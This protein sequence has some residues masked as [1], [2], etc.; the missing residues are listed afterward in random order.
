MQK[1]INA[2]LS[3]NEK[4]KEQIR[5]RFLTRK[6]QLVNIIN[7]LGSKLNNLNKEVSKEIEVRDVLLHQE[8]ARTRKLRSE[9]LKA[10]D[11]LMSNDLAFKARD[12]FKTLVD[13][14]DEDKMFLEGGQLNDLLEKERLNRQTF[15][16]ARESDNQK[17]KEQTK[18]R[19]RFRSNQINFR[20]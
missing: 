13:L 18:T 15:E 1:W 17:Y 14:T 5:L 8:Q 3:G 16:F 12:V 4:E 20:N 6:S 7:T 10:K 9:I 19:Q 2:E 11:V